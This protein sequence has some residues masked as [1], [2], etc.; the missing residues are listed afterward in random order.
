MTLLLAIPINGVLIRIIIA[1]YS[2]ISGE[3]SFGGGGRPWHQIAPN[4]VR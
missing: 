4:L 2:L 1:N 3:F